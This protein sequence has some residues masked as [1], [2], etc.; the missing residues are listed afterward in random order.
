MTK[1]QFTFNLRP[2]ATIVLAIGCF[3]LGAGAQR[4]YDS[5]RSAGAAVPPQSVT[6]QVDFASEPLW[7]YG[8]STVRKPEET[9]SPQAP[10]TR[11]LRANEDAIEQTRPRTLTGSAAA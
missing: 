2:L 4:Y 7:A 11:D 6:P 10:P 5:H 9:A 3:A 1:R 8:F